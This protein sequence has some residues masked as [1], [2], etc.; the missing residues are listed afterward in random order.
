MAE[1]VSGS[2][3]LAELAARLKIAGDRDLR[4]QLLRG[5]RAAA[6]PLVPKVKAAALAQLPKRGGLNA[7]VAGQKVSVSV[8]TSARTAGVRLTTSAPDTQ[9]A[10]DGYVRH[11][12]FGNRAHWVVQ[13]IPGAAGW[14]SATLEREAPATAPHLLEAM[15]VVAIQVQ[16]GL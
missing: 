13:Q 9:Q 5:M 1:V 4:L 15:E 10:D 3:Q 2:K 12:V 8:R 16:G 7:H 11:P 6:E 14:W